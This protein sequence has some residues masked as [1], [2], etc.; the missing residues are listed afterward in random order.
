VDSSDV[1][2]T[3]DPVP[4]SVVIFRDPDNIQ[5]ELIYLAGDQG[6][7]LGMI[8]RPERRLRTGL[9]VMRAQRADR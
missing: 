8:W 1:T 6:D 5:L 7:H 9:V 4:R 3:R 2:D